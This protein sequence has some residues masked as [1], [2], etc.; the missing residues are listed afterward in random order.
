MSQA[1]YK[2]EKLTL[3]SLLWARHIVKIMIGIRINSLYNKLFCKKNTIF[4]RFTNVIQNNLVTAMPNSQ[5][6]L[7]SLGLFTLLFLSLLLAPAMFLAIDSDWSEGFHHPLEGWDHLIAMVAVGIWSAQLRGKAVWLLPLV[8]A[9]I[10]SLGGLAGAASFAVPNAEIIILL[11]SLILNI[12]IIRKIRFSMPLNMLIVAFFAFFHGYAHGE[13]ISTSASLFS[14]TAGFVFATLL[15]HGAGILIARLT[16]LILAFFVSNNLGAQETSNLTAAS[17]KDTIGIESEIEPETDNDTQVVFKEIKVT[18]QANSLVGIADS[19]SQ[20]IVT[21]DQMKFRPITRP[22]EILE[23]VPGMIATQHSGEGKANQ[24]FLRGFNLDHGTDFLTQIDGVPV[25]QLSHSHGQ[26]WTDTNFLI[27]E[28]IETLDYKK[29][30]SHAENGDFSSVGS[31]NIRYFKSLPDNIIQFTGG[32]FDYYRGLVAGSHQLG[33]GNLLYAGEVVHND[34][35]W[36]IGNNYLK[37]NGVLRYSQIRG[38]SGW[39]VTAMGMQSDWR[40]TD[41]IARRALDQGIIGRFD[42]LDPTTGGSSQRYSLNSEW[43]HKDENSATQL[44]TYGV[45]SEL[46]LFSNFTLFLDDNENTNPVGCAGLNGLR[47]GQRFSSALFNTCGDQFGQPDERWTTGFKGSHTIF[48]NFR[49]IYSETTFGLQVR[50][51][52]IRNA[53]TKTHGQKQVGITRK[54]TIW[55]TSVSPYLENKTSWN[56]WLRTSLGVRF[57]GFRFNVSDS[58]NSV[59]NGERYDGLFSPKF[60]VVLGPWADTEFYLN[61]GLGFHSNDARGINTRID[62]ATG[63]PVNRA[64]PLVRTYSA[65]VGVRTSWVQGLQTTLVGWWLDVD[66]ELLFVGDAG[67]TEASRPSRRYGLEFVNYY[68]PV[69]WLTLD[70]DFS[71]SHSRF[72]DDVPGEGNFVPNSIETVIAAGATVHDVFDGFYGGPRL[73]FLG[74]RALN[75]DN[76]ARSDS[77]LLVSALLG[78]QFNKSLSVRAEVFNILNRKDDAITYFFSSRL[79]GE[80]SNGVNDFHFHPVEPV[81]FRMSLTLK[82]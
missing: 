54:D 61:G 35:P 68:S 3:I 11:S 13:E 65:E 47:S 52:N 6:L 22:G 70:A 18:D 19:A 5:K 17:T 79:P 26:G 81:S 23:T 8:F 69:H 46:D 28:L 48:H 12:F 60:G 56:D 36:T 67:A 39:S 80:T 53:L 41:Q 45:Y 31:A 37:F 32:S 40:S 20:G 76:S 71:F 29:G 58:N 50:N 7:L 82:F 44:M 42:A 30:N 49:D 43:Y 74:P 77:T 10:M 14:Y 27:P 33:G 34:G 16:V 63:D 21:Q 66:S 57:D 78:Y 62:P 24:Y 73:R 9:S 4:L 55:V 51:D 64:D 1:C 15:L 38:N 72:R 25:N 75:E 2:F 59:N